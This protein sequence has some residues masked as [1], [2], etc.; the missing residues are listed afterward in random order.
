MDLLLGPE[1]YESIYSDLDERMVEM[2]SSKG[3]SRSGNF[4]TT[5]WNPELKLLR[6][7]QASVEEDEE[8]RLSR[9]QSEVSLDD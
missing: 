1:I 2:T 4:D 8:N 3:S 6:I 5:G 7:L 9:A